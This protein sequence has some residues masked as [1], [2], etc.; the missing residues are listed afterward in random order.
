MIKKYFSGC[1][2]GLSI[3]IWIFS[4][5]DYIQEA[6]NSAYYHAQ[7]AVLHGS[8]ADKEAIKRIFFDKKITVHDYNAIVFPIYLTTVDGAQPIFPEIQKSKSKNMLKS[9]LEDLLK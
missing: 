3:A 6:N 8:N 2:V 4:P 7:Y 9:E 5:Y 1:V